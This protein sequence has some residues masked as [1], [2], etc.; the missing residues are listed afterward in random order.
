MHSKSVIRVKVKF[1]E[2]SFF[3]L[4]PFRDYTVIT[5][6][7]RSS[8]RR[9]S[10]AT[11]LTFALKK[12]SLLCRPPPSCPSVRLLSTILGATVAYQCDHLPAIRAVEDH[13]DICTI[14]VGKTEF[15]YVEVVLRMFRNAQTGAFWLVDKKVS[16][17]PNKG[18]GEGKG[19]FA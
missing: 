12:T 9:S 16:S 8:G 14:G 2:F 13:F 4:F 1:E 19:G 5:T 15:K 6:M 11:Q 18:G 17:I 3:S 7:S 10:L